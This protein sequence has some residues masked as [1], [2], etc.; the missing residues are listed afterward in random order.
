[1]VHLPWAIKDGGRE[2]VKAMCEA[3]N[4]CT[5]GETLRRIREAILRG[6]RLHRMIT[7][8]TRDKFHITAPTRH[9]LKPL[10]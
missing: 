2:L 7:C 9:W 10:V 5:V 4:G 1:M 3:Y 6:E 8:P